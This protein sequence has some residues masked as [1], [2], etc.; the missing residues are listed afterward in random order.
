MVGDLA[1]LCTDVVTYAGG[2]PT[3]CPTSQIIAYYAYENMFFQ[4]FDVAQKAGCNFT[5]YVDDMTFSSEKAFDVNML[6][7]DIDIILRKYGHKPKYKKMKYYTKGK[8]TPITGTIVTSDHKL[9]VPN[10]L[11]YKIYSGFQELK[12]LTEEDGL[13]FQSNKARSLKGQLQAA[14]SI[15][16]RKFPEIERLIKEQFF[17]RTHRNQG[18]FPNFPLGYFFW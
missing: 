3:G 5:L 2:I 15:E 4:I 18:L 17:L 1:G 14:K 7:K 9:K 12:K 16:P 10:N 13:L 6:K 11:Q 8:A